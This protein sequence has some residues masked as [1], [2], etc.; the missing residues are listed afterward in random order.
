[1]IVLL[2]VCVQNMCLY[3]YLTVHIYGEKWRVKFYISEQFYKK[4]MTKWKKKFVRRFHSYTISSN[5]YM[6]TVMWLHMRMKEEERWNLI[7]FFLNMWAIIGVVIWTVSRKIRS[8]NKTIMEYPNVGQFFS[9][10]SPEIKANI[11]SL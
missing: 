1:M 8:I 7:F 11:R 10:F 4:S 3:I 9:S 2:P 6:Y 5:K